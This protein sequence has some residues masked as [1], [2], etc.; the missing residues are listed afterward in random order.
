MH[1]P[2]CGNKRCARNT[3]LSFLFHPLRS[4]TSPTDMSTAAAIGD[5]VFSSAPP[6]EPVTDAEIRQQKYLMQVIRRE[7]KE[8]EIEL[9]KLHLHCLVA[10]LACRNRA[11]SSDLVRAVAL[12]TLPSS[13]VGVGPACSSSDVE[14]DTVAISE[15][16]PTLAALLA[17]FRA[18]FT[19]ESTPSMSGSATIVASTTSPAFS[20]SE[21]AFQDLRRARGKQSAVPK[22]RLPRPRV[23]TP[24]TESVPIVVGSSDESDDDTCRGDGGGGNA[25]ADCG[26]KMSKGAHRDTHGLS[27][28]EDDD[29]PTFGLVTAVQ[30]L[31]APASVLAELF[32]VF[33]RVLGFDSRLVRLPSCIS[34][35]TQSWQAF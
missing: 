12:S 4:L 22:T 31:A 5:V 8:A 27:V 6:P 21:S 34:V 32:V 2:V 23:A 11:L 15:N 9:H 18:S 20:S 29:D 7:R 28:D 10:A 24:T 3:S 14:I 19:L 25:T 13:W 1:V 30:H 16:T 35:Q 17:W 26:E 33:C